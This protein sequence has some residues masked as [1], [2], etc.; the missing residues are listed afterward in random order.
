MSISTPET[1]QVENPGN[2]QVRTYRYAQWLY[3]KDFI[4]G[5]LFLFSPLKVFRLTTYHES[6]YREFRVLEVSVALELFLYPWYYVSG[7]SLD[8]YVSEVK[9]E[10]RRRF[11][12]WVV[13][14]RDPESKV[15][16]F[17]VL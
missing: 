7:V 14:L 3:C 5:P 2:V 11:G 4:R 8:L 1:L 16:A 12:F 13:K 9:I 6:V 15:Q 10:L 17:F